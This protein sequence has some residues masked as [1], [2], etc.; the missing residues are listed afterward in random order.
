MS[1]AASDNRPLPAPTSAVWPV[2]FLGALTVGCGAVTVRRM[3]GMA[4]RAI[5]IVPDHVPWLTIPTS[6]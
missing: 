6:M 3:R 2:L 4:R 5:V 1:T